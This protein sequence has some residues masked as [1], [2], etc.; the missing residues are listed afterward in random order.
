MPSRAKCKS[1]MVSDFFVIMLI[2]VLSLQATKTFSCFVRYQNVWWWPV[3][4]GRHGINGISTDVLFQGSLKNA[5]KDQTYR[6][7]NLQINKFH[8]HAT[9]FFRIES[10]FKPWLCWNSK[11]L[12]HQQNS[13]NKKTVHSTIPAI[14]HQKAL[15]NVSTKVLSQSWLIEPTGSMQ[16]SVFLHPV[17]GIN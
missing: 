3:W 1:R 15:Y 16:S 9:T 14:L 7:K 10:R 12:C 4:T 8:L 17:L 5:F 13:E 11:T 2:N 6:T